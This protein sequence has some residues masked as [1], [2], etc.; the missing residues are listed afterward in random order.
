MREEWRR[1]T[2]QRS[3][4]EETDL[5]EDIPKKKRKKRGEWRKD[6]DYSWGQRVLTDEE[7]GIRK[8][9]YKQEEVNIRVAREVSGNVRVTRL[10]QQNPKEMFKTNQTSKPAIGVGCG[11]NVLQEGQ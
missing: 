1:G 3:Y 4:N 6:A 5:D 11:E 2:V 10:K 7:D 8:W 9:L